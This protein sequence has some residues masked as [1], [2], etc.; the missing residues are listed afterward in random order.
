MKE[1][2]KK[3]FKNPIWK[4]I[5]VGLGVIGILDWVIFPSLT[6]PSTIFNIFGLLVAAAVSVFVGI[7]IKEEFL[8]K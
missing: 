8:N 7:Y 6:V 2:L 4:H 5:L 1:I 3:T